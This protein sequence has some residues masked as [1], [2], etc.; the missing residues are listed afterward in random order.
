MKRVA[1]LLSFSLLV[2]ACG[3]ESESPDLAEQ[4]GEAA[5]DTEVLREAQS[6]ANEILRNAADCE[7]V[8]RI[9]PE[10]R[11]KLDVEVQTQTGRQALE[12]LRTQVKRVTDT[13]GIR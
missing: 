13:C 12:A 5:A 10:V 2:L 7:H 9:W 4:A 8:A 1:S 6:A 11:P 3:G